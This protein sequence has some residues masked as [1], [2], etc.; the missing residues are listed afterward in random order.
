MPL[1]LSPSGKR[2]IEGSDHCS[3]ISGDFVPFRDNATQADTATAQRRIDQPVGQRVEPTCFAALM[4][5]HETVPVIGLLLPILNDVACQS[6]VQLALSGYDDTPAPIRS[7]PCATTALLSWYETRWRVLPWRAPAEAVLVYAVWLSEI[8]LQQTTVA[9]VKAYFN[10]FIGRW[11]DVRA[12]A[13]APRDDVLA[14]WAGLGYYARARSLHAAAVT[15][16]EQH[17]RRFPILRPDC[18]PAGWPYATA[19][20]AAIAFGRRAVVV[21]GNIERVTARWQDVQIPLPKAK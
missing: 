3:G 5:G 12:L 6:I 4:S 19:A 17:D 11:P 15:V 14:A 10:A 20:I 2:I 9:T 13:A 18:R 8:M 1:R 16:A 7:P 21:G